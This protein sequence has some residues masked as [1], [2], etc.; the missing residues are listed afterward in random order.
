[1]DLLEEAPQRP[2]ST[3]VL[4]L[5]FDG[6]TDTPKARQKLIN[7]II[8]YCLKNPQYDTIAVAIGSLRQSVAT[9]YA[10]AEIHYQRFG[11]QLISCSL[12]LTEFTTTLATQLKTVLKAKAPKV[13]NIKMLTS[14]ILNDLP[15]GTTLNAMQTREYA[16]ISEACK[17]WSI[18]IQD[19]YNRCELIETYSDEAFEYWYKN[20]IKDLDE[21]RLEKFLSHWG[22]DADYFE[23]Y[24][25]WRK[26][27]LPAITVTNNSGYEQPLLVAER[28]CYPHQASSVLL[29]DTSKVFT[30]YALHQYLNTHPKFKKP[31]HLLHFDDKEELLIGIE[32]FY[33]TNPMFMAAGVSYQSVLWNA[34][35]RF[36]PTHIKERDIIYGTGLANQNFK[37]DL[38]R[39][40]A[41]FN[42]DTNP[43]QWDLLSRLHSQCYWTHCSQTHSKAD[44]LELYTIIE[45]D[46]SSE[47]D[48]ATPLNL[49][50]TESLVL[51]AAKDKVQ[52]TTMI[53]TRLAGATPNSSDIEAPQLNNETETTLINHD[54]KTSNT[55][56][57]SELVSLGQL[58]IV[59][60]PTAVYAGT[61]D[62]IVRTKFL[63]EFSQESSTSSG[64]DKK[65]IVPS[66]GR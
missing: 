6:C 15:I 50:T 57:D 35:S 59:R 47:S 52:S 41:S 14:D 24:V 42:D 25:K 39:V 10:N 4:S 28:C 63:Q 37:W 64:V 22:I 31:F 66:C 5:D 48:K 58:D 12:L 23:D 32:K 29:N 7:Y 26:S 46:E 51:E 21:N 8:M 56:S 45:T 60:R 19:I 33:S 61:S 53:M 54:T 18:F 16:R 13:Q 2:A 44:T 36:E 65:N 11:N 38:I 30:L 1:M 20:N 40:V 27:K 55:Q 9:D 49:D 43:P 17:P 62:D 34:R 3:L